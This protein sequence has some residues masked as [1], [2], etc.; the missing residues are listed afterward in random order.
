MNLK[1]AELNCVKT[2][3]LF[4]PEFKQFEIGIST[5]LYFPAMGTAGLDLVYVSGNS[6]VPLPPPKTMEITLRFIVY[7]AFYFIKLTFLFLMST[8]TV[9]AIVE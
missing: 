1:E 6:L 8:F 5:N 7:F 2:R 3:I 9:K 4:I